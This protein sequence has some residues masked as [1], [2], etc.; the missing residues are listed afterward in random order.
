MSGTLYVVATPIGNLEDITLRALRVL[1][2]VDVIAAEDTR[3]TARLLSHHGISSPTV[4]FHEHNKRTRVPQLVSR[5]Q[6]GENIAVV[7]DAGTPGVSDPGLELVQAAVDGR[8]TVDPIPG[9]SAPLTALIASGFPLVPFT[10]FGFAPNRSKA[11]I[12]WLQEVANT[13][14]TFSFFEAPHRVQAALRDMGILFGERPII[15]A[16]EMTKLHQE[17]IRGTAGELS[18]LLTTPRGEFT[19]V[20]GPQYKQLA[21]NGMQLTD[22]EVA[23]EFWQITETGG[24]PRRKIISDIARRS[25]R[26]ARDVYAAIERTKKLGRIT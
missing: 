7:T 1:R 26:S 4:S 18:K 3:R 9:V 20:V 5:L 25:G 8:I 22:N 19:V 24:G 21:T 11:R 6:A 14:H 13:P 10:M 17:F 15:V 16:R 23:L 2:E 12:I